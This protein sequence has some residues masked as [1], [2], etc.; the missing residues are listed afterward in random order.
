MFQEAITYPTE[1]DDWTK[2]VLIG[3]VLV[4]AGVLIVPT[5]LVYG[6]LVEV[7][8][9]RFAGEPTP[10][11]FDDW[12]DLLIDGLQAWAVGVVYLLL[13]LIV[14][15]ILVGGSV[16][17]LATGSRAGGAVGIAGLL[18]GLGVTTLLSL[19]FG[20]VAIA[21]IINFAHEGTFGAAFDIGT[22]RTVCL[23]SDYA[24]AWLASVVV[25]FAAAAVSGVLNVVPILGAVASAFL[26]FYASVAAAYLWADGFQAA[27]DT[28][29]EFETG[30]PEGPAV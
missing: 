28:T 9:G 10:P 2:T 5:F 17:A 1:S 6:Y 11:A 26:F 4:L 12:R 25:F 7:L 13:P 29:G 18:G 24:V 30:T 20:Y 23:D 8:R 14:G 3:G 21:G 27:L 22:L 15:G 16:A 19:V